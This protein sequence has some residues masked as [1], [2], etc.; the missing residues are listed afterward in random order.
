[1][2]RSHCSQMTNGDYIREALKVLR[3]LNDVVAIERQSSLLLN[4]PITYIVY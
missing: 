2:K 4:N 3:T 1:M